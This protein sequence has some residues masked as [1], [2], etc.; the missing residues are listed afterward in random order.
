M[1]LKENMFKELANI[2]QSVWDFLNEI[3]DRLACWLFGNSDKKRRPIDSSTRNNVWRKY[4]GDKTKEKCFCCKNRPIFFD[5]FDVG[6][7]IPVS[8]GGGDNMDNLRPICRPCNQGMSD[9]SMT[10]YI[11]M[12]YPQ[13]ERSA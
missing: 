9:M 8:K 1:R 4:V 10:E 7:I 2:R 13:S 12:Y 6:H 5:N 11:E 3:K